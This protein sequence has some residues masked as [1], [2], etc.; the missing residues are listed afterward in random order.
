MEPKE[1]ASRCK[2]YCDLDLAATEM[3]QD[4]VPILI[5]SYNL[6]FLSTPERLIEF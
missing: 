6:F 4:A 3:H 2:S 5:I 1:K